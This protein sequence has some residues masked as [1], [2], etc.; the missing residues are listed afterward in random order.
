MIDGQPWKAGF[1]RLD[2]GLT[3]LTLEDIARKAVSLESFALNLGGVVVDQLP[4]YEKDKLASLSRLTIETDKLDLAAP[5][6]TIKTI[7]LQEPYVAVIV[8][9]DK[10]TNL[11]EIKN[12]FG[13]GRQRLWTIR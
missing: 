7:V 11:Q 10:V 6:L 9:A 1:D 4:G 13:P 8:G 5:T 3:Q 2:I 12:D